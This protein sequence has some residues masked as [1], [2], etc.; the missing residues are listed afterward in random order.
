[1]KK[2]TAVLFTTLF[3]ASAFSQTVGTQENQEF[4]ILIKPELSFKHCAR[5][6]CTIAKLPDN[7]L[8]KCQILKNVEIVIAN[9]NINGYNK[10]LDSGCVEAIEVSRQVEPAPRIGRGN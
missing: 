8:G 7:G 2:I 3:M 10:V 6:I 5:K 9:L 1:M 4:L